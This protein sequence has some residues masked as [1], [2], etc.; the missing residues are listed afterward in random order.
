MIVG[1]LLLFSSIKNTSV[2][3][4][5]DNPGKFENSHLA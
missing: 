2:Y 3:K 1:A 4:F 5:T